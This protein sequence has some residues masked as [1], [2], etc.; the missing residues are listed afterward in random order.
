V[1]VL[2][3]QQEL[4]YHAAR[5]LLL[6]AFC[7]RPARNPFIKGR[8]L[9]AKLDFFLRYPAY[10]DKAVKI[11]LGTSLENLERYES[12]NVETHMIR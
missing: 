1:S 3:E 5:I 12:E 11:K 10:L 4:T 2:K 8:T 6:I 9:L 7:G